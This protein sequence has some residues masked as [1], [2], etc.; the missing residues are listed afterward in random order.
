MDSNDGEGI[1][2]RNSQA[3]HKL[4]IIVLRLQESLDALRDALDESDVLV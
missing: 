4:H 2:V 1:Y 3:L